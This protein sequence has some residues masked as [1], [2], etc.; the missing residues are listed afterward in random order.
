MP[1]AIRFAAYVKAAYNYFTELNT[2]EEIARVNTL[3]ESI[4]GSYT[5]TPESTGVTNAV[6][7]VTSV[8][9]NLDEKPTIRFYVTDTNIKFYAD[10]KR[11]AIVKGTDNNYGAYVELD[12][13]AYTLCDTITYGDGGSY[14]VS[15]FVAGSKGTAHEALV[16][17][18]VKY[19]ES[20]ANYRS[21]VIN[22]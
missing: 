11:L 22:K 18:F 6:A 1:F 17:A 14:H 9:L 8:T 12:V 3:V 5:A 20:A 4:I 13:Y 21:F 2:T 15:D 7:P 19:V 16:N 10:G